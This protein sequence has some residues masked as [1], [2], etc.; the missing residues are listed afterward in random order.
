MS[1]AQVSWSQTIGVPASP[2]QSE[3]AEQGETTGEQIP[4]T[5]TPAGVQMRSR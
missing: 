4:Q 5:G 2:T 3:S 1:Q